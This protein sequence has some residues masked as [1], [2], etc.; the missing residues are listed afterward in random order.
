MKDTRL[1]ESELALAVQFAYGGEAFRRARAAQA[2]QVGRLVK[3]LW[4]PRSSA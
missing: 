4:R 3:R 2:R 1:T